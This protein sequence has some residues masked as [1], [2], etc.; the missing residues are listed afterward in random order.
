M[1]GWSPSTKWL[2]VP[3]V[4]LFGK[5]WLTTNDEKL[6]EV[7]TNRIAFVPELHPKKLTLSTAE[8]LVMLVACVLF[9]CT[10]EKPIEVT[11]K[12]TAESKIVFI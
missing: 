5:D 4:E 11:R 1:P 10:C 2:I 8:V 9:H 6:L 3:G 7:E 12:N